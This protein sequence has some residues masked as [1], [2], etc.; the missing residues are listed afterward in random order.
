MPGN[1][2]LIYMD[3]GDKMYLGSISDNT[4]LS[5]AKWTSSD[6]SIAKVSSSGKV[7]AVSEGMCAIAWINGSQSFVFYI[8]VEG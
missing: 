1:T 6:T 5:S 4:V 8:Y 2:I 3:E 7:T